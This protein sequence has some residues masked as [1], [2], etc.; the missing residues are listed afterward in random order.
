MKSPS[1]L[2]TVLLVALCT[3][4][5][6]SQAWSQAAA[7]LTDRERDLLNRIDKLEARITA[8]ESRTT[9]EAAPPDSSATASAPA[10]DAV[11]SVPP[12]STTVVPES[13]AAPANSSS[14][15]FPDGTTLNFSVD[16]Y[17]G[18][19]FNHP[20]GRVNFLRSND[21]LSSNLSLNQIGFVVE[22]A[23]D[24]SVNRPIGYRVDLMFGQNTETL[25]GGGQN[26]PRPQVYRNI[27]QAFGSYIIPVGSGLQLDF[28]KFASSLG[29]EGNYTKDQL[30]YSRSYFFNALPF[31]HMG[32]RGTYNVNPKLSLQYWLVNGA[33][34]TEDFNGFKSQAVLFTY[35]PAPKVSWNINYYEGQES[36]DVLPASNSPIPTLPTQPGLSVNAVS[37]P[38]NGRTH[39]FDSYAAFILNSKWSAAL[40]G[41]YVISRLASNS[42]PTR[43]YGGAGYLHRQLT[44][45]IALNERFEY[46]KDRG[47]FTGATQDL[48]EVTATALFQPVDG[49]QTRIEY[50]RDFTNRN[51]F[52]T[53]NP[54]FPV[55]SQSTA[56]VGLNW[57][58]GGKTGS[59]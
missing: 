49:F 46:I 47:L 9:K 31:Y 12:T 6:D 33:N 53:N 18:Y 40:E 15:A 26:E 36:H 11:Q 22:R 23:P 54:A 50:R 7:P 44:K 19:N 41:D 45:T 24:L 27:Y 13:N 34:E 16:G 10:K 25:Q 4:L 32:L 55:A 8:L 5:F 58:F 3:V 52:L 28:G 48:K 35:K 38:H 42:S 20:T 14:L 29:I 2:S 39:I 43:F 1:A 30:N 57:W 21:V 37:E 56:T 17:Y 59:W 51:F